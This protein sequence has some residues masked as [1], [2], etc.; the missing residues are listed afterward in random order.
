MVVVHSPPLPEQTPPSSIS[1]LQ[2]LSMASQ[3]SSEGWQVGG[4]STGGSVTIG[5]DSAVSQSPFTFTHS[6][7]SI[8]VQ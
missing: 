8:Q 2:L 5:A 6:P 7:S 3:I 1:P 4:S